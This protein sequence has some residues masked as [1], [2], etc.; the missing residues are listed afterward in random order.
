MSNDKYEFIECSNISV[1]GENYVAAIRKGG[2][3]I[4]RKYPRKLYKAYDEN[5]EIR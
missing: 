4:F 1:E 5:G 2:E 3:T